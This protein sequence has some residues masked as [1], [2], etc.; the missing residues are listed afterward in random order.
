MAIESKTD[1]GRV[2]DKD[3]P[4]KLI[5]SGSAAGKRK[6]YFYMEA[7]EEV[8]IADALCRHCL[9]VYALLSTAQAMHPQDEWHTL[10]PHQLV[11]TGLSRYQVR[12]AIKKLEKAGIVE[13]SRKPGRKTRYRL[14]ASEPHS[15]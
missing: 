10:P 9:A 12:W 15:T 7:T 5:K 6:K 11:A 4:T 13:V 3:I 2:A 8:G 1:W 14:L